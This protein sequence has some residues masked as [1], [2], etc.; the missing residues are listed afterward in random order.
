MATAPLP[1]TPSP[2]IEFLRSLETLPEG[3]PDSETLDVLAWTMLGEAANQGDDGLAAIAN[4]IQNRAGSGD[5]PADLKRVALQKKQFSTWNKGEGGNNPKARYPKSS[6]E[7][8]NARRI[9]ADVVS[10]RRPDITGGATHYWSPK[11]MTAM[12]Y[13]ET[14]YWAEGEKS[15]W[16]TLELGDHVFLPKKPVPPNDI[17]N[18]K[19][20]QNAPL[21]L[22]KPKAVRLAQAMN[23]VLGP[24]PLPAPRPLAAN[25]PL[26]QRASLAP[27]TVVRTVAIDPTTGFPPKSRDVTPTPRIGSV[28]TETRYA[29][30]AGKGA[31]ASLDY[32]APLP[33]PPVEGLIKLRPGRDMREESWGVGGANQAGTTRMA[34]ARPSIVADMYEQMGVEDP[35]GKPLRLDRYNSADVLEELDFD[36]LKRDYMRAKIA[37]KRQ[38]NAAFPVG[39]GAPRAQ[40]RAAVPLPRP[41][42]Q[43]AAPAKRTPIS[44][45]VA[46]GNRA[47]MVGPPPSQGAAMVVNPGTSTGQTLE[48]MGFS[49]GAA[50]PAATIRNLES[51]GYFN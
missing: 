4:V 6:E 42:P 36:A 27:A 7:F 12:G 32:A 50:V 9:A 51:R 49:P 29:P 20:T 41:R 3:T 37:P 30:G 46:G 40:P 15:K 45:L 47:P 19:G 13:A 44:I 48:S 10:G 17:P 24:R 5:Y 22:D 34:A 8:Q 31:S 39:H 33:K 21:P 11:G 26:E 18:G 28:K 38:G 35:L 16:G 1:L 43:I 2:Y 23:D 14:P 25:N